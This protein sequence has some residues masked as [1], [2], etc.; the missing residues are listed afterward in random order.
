MEASVPEVDFEKL[1][2]GE[3]LKKLREACEKY[4]ILRVINHPIPETLMIEMKS[5]V[6]FMHDLPLEIKMRNKSIIP[7]SGY[8]PPHPSS[9]LYEAMAIYDFHKSPQ[10]LEDF[11]SQLDLPP[12]YRKIV[13]SY[14]KAIHELASNIAKE[15][16]KSLG[17]EDVDF[18]DWPF[19][20]RSIKYNFS[21]ENI[22]E[23]GVMLHSDTGF[24]T[25]IQDDETVSGLELLDDSGLFKVVTPKPGSLLCIVG[26]V[27]RVWSN[28]KFWN[29]R[30]R[31]ICN[32]TCTRYSFGVFMLAARDGIVEAHPKLA[33]RNDAPRYRPFK[34]ED[35]RQFRIVTGKRNA[36]VLDQY[37][38]A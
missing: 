9:P 24:I 2:E 22:G 18:K 34:Y 5:V 20:L 19:I 23:I 37:R 32:E 11:F 14:G 16:G 13:K 29:A 21:P 3:E 38:I 6:K 33:E 36:E 26:D 35:L 27:G 15:M 17:I 12:H 31:V 10:A 1:S 7:D 4:G 8:I 28:E 25:L 30:H